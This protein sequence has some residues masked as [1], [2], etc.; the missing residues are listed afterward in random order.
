[1]QLVPHA[2]PWQVKG[3]QFTVCDWQVP[4]PLHVG[5]FCTPPEQL[6]GAH[7]VLAG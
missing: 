6:W 5:L 3:A 4:V 2:V 7:T 1:M